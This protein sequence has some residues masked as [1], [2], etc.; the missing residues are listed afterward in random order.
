[1]NAKIPS[2]ILVLAAVAGPASAQQQ[3]V[4][5]DRIAKSMPNAYRA[6]ECGIKPNHFK[7]SSGATYLRTSIETEVPENKARSLANGQ[8]VILEAMQQNGQD[9][10]PAAWYYLGRIYLYQ[11]DLYGADSA[12]TRAEQLAPKCAEE[13]SNYRK[14]AWVG[15][16]KAGSKFEED[17]NTDSALVLYREAGSIY[18]NSP[19]TYYQLAAIM[20]DK[21]EVDSA[22]AYFGRAAAAGVNSTDTTEVKVRNRSSFNQGAILLNKKDYAGAAAAFEKYLGRVPA[23]NEA[24]RGLAASYRGLGQV[25]KAQ[26]LE[27][28]LVSAG[29]VP[30]AGAAAGTQDLMSAGVN[31]Y[32]DKK[33]AEAAAAFEKAAAAEPYNR[34]ALSNLSNAYLALKDG[35]K[36]LAA[37][38]KLVAIEPMSE[39]A[40]KLEGEGY[41]QSGNVN[42]AVKT[43]EK[44]L[45]LPIDVKV[46]EF[47]P[48]ASGASLGATAT[49]R[50][51]QTPS[52]KPIAPAP[53]TVVF[54]FLDTSGGVVTTQETAV[55]A[56]K[57]GAAQDIKLTAQG[58]GIV[59]W[60]YKRK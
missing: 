19:I 39:A 31:L 12:L 49:G 15:L 13:I 1:M 11:G 51:A 8:K 56:L 58:A 5:D 55:P 44:V 18:R 30:G 26:A 20:N 52:G 59:A 10:N 2:A 46:A 17:K 25:E 48:N 47:S 57:A 50:D 53:V 9:K 45:A 28:E 36:L 27:K 7:V 23:D 21:G 16:V 37:A 34:D 29:G 60:R 40:L 41:K 32:N 35:K 42:D 4:L 54:E 33:F 43:A 24:K 22:A 14:N 6:A 3:Q 38:T